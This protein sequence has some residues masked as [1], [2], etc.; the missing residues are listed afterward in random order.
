M[1]SVLKHTECPACGHRHHF[2][3]LRDDLQPGQD[4]EYICP[5]TAKKSRLRPTTTAEIFRFPPQ[6]AVVLERV[7]RRTQAEVVAEGDGSTRL[8]DVLP[9]VNDLANRVG[10]LEHLGELVKTLKETKE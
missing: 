6:G 10:G 7:A 3:F 4:F 1:A 5:E 2:C 8:Q 9:E